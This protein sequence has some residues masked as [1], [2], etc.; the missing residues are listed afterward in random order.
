[1]RNIK[2]VSPEQLSSYKVPTSNYNNGAFVRT[3]NFNR[4]N[5][6]NDV[7][8]NF[9]ATQNKVKPYIYRG[10]YD[11]NEVL[12]YDVT[13]YEILDAGENIE[14]VMRYISEEEREYINYYIVFECIG[15]VGN[16]EFNEVGLILQETINNKGIF[17]TSNHTD[18]FTGSENK[19]INKK[20]ATFQRYDKQRGFT[21][22][23]NAFNIDRIINI[24][25]DPFKLV[26]YTEIKILVAVDTY[27]F[28]GDGATI[29]QST[30]YP[31]E[32]P[33]TIMGWVKF[34]DAT[35]LGY[36]GIGFFNPNDSEPG[37]Q[38]N[39]RLYSFIQIVS[40]TKYEFWI[41]AYD[42]GA[43][44]PIFT[45]SNGDKIHVCTVIDGAG[46]V[47]GYVNGNLV[48]TQTYTYNN[49][50]YHGFCPTY[51]RHTD[52]SGS[53]ENPI[54]NKQIVY[55]VKYF[56]AEL[57][58]LQIQAEMSDNILTPKAYWPLNKDT[59]DYSGNNYNATV[60]GTKQYA[61][62]DQN[63]ELQDVVILDNS[64]RYLSAQNISIDYTSSANQYVNIS[65][66]GIEEI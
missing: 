19:D 8:V 10:Y 35:N 28:D 39:R 2:L 11:E 53:P 43:G 22:T 45:P 5:F 55:D 6:R 58:Q 65:V 20:Y 26:D 61:I 16:I 56:E 37:I 66:T 34:S 62:V 15:N 60:T 46:N 29:V 1:M 32:T 31:T 9:T 54:Y 23:T 40:S 41:G 47:Y 44:V 14:F 13:A 49:I 27:G 18:T 33:I 52:V 17:A 48:N 63:E 25:E 51:Y 38:N 36:A 42:R 30:L 4:N 21:I 24:L 59:I 57:S 64:T 12:Q 50:S 7:Y 3:Y